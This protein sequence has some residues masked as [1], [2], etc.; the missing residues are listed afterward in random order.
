MAEGYVWHEETRSW[1]KKETL[2]ERKKAGGSSLMHGSYGGAASHGQPR[3]DHQTGER[4]HKPFAYNEDES[5]STHNWMHN[6]NGLHRVGAGKPPAGGAAS[7]GHINENT[8]HSKLNQDGHLDAHSTSKTG[9]TKLPDGYTHPSDTS[10]PKPKSMGQQA[11]EGVKS[12][13]ARALEN[14]KSGTPFLD[15]LKGMFFGKKGY[16][17]AEGVALEAFLKQYGVH[18]HMKDKTSVHDLLERLEEDDEKEVN[19]SL[20]DSIIR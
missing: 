9:V 14:K 16:P 11:K 19:K 2:E 1:I 20:Q 12:G 13:I 4:L 15:G 3:F 6:E 10:P 18:E 5:D 8:L 17:M 7:H